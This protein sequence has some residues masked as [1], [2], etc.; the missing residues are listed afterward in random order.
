MGLFGGI[1]AVIYACWFVAYVAR[2]PTMFALLDEM[3]SGQQHFDKR[4]DNGLLPA[5]PAC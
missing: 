2:T 1:A 3:S 4:I 5:F